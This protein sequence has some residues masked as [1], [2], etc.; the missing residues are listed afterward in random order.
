MKIVGFNI[1]KISAER[2]EEVSPNSAVNTNIDYLEAEEQKMEKDSKNKVLKV[3][4]KFSV[5]YTKTEGKKEQKQ[6][7]CNI[8][9]LIFLLSSEEETKVFLKD[10]KKDGFSNTVK[11]NLFNFIS[12]RCISKVVQLQTDLSLPSPFLRIPQVQVSQL[13]ENKKK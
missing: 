1:L 4:F 7:E 13:P 6:A 2:M 3:K 10:W 8:E 5:D 12:R 9:G 11:S